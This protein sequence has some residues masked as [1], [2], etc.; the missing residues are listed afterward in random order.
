MEMIRSCGWKPIL[1]ISS[2]WHWNLTSTAT[3][4]HSLY[5]NCACVATDNPPALVN[6]SSNSSRVEPGWMV[7]IRFMS[8]SLI[9]S[10][11][12]SEGIVFE[13]DR[14]K[15]AQ[16]GKASNR[17]EYDFI[18]KQRLNRKIPDRELNGSNKSP[19]VESIIITQ[20]FNV[21]LKIN[22]L[23]KI[24]FEKGHP[25]KRNH[26]NANGVLD[27]LLKSSPPR[28]NRHFPKN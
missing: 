14:N 22:N 8:S 10:F 27:P 3:V 25:K 26:Q 6:T 12:N 15:Q 18:E 23:R 11:T 1:P 9:P 16:K 24:I 7:L 5:L 4:R 21:S 20:T 19:L 2:R 28:Q 13:H 17:M